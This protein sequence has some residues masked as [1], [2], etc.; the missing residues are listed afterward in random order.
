MIH[1]LRRCSSQIS[2]D[3]QHGENDRKRVQKS[4]MRC[5][6]RAMSRKGRIEVLTTI[7]TNFALTTRY[8]R[9]VGYARPNC[10]NNLVENERLH[11]THT[12][13]FLFAFDSSHEQR[14]IPG[15]DRKAQTLTVE[16]TRSACAAIHVWTCSSSA[17][18][19]QA[20]SGT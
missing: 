7:N 15:F 10:R 8:L 2:S 1:G 12:A 20:Q 13:A 4:N 16:R 5:R 17:P 6:Y 19:A 18:S 14:S 9:Y 3:V 11:Q